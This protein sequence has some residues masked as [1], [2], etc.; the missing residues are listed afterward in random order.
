MDE[1]GFYYC[2]DR[3][4]ELIK[5]SKSWEKCLVLCFE[6]RQGMVFF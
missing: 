1:K 4:K 2:T 5:Y 3:L 6:D